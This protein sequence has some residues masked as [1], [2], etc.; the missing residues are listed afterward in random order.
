MP[1]ACI[2]VGARLRACGRTLGCGGA[3]PVADHKHSHHER[4]RSWPHAVSDTCTQ[5]ARI[6]DLNS[7]NG[8]FVNDGRIQDGACPLRSG[9]TVRFGYDKETYR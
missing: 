7:M 8:T 5:R 1:L 9:D 2:A 3:W 6:V 4:H